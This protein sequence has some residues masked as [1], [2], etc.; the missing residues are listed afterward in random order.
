MSNEESKKSR[1]R[2]K[3]CKTCKKKQELN[4]GETIEDQEV[5]VNPNDIELVYAF[6][7]NP[8]LLKEDKNRILA[9]TIFKQVVGDD[10][11][12]SMCWSCKGSTIKRK[13]KYHAESKYGIKLR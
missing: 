2:K 7:N 12:V 11:N 13:F 1:T 3:P 9:E 6:L 4:L 10:L 8:S 5:L